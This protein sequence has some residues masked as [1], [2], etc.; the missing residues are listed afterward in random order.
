MKQVIEVKNITLKPGEGMDTLLVKLRKE[1]IHTDP[2]H[3]RIVKKS[4][5]ARDKRDLHY[6]CT[7]RIEGSLSKRHS[8]KC[9]MVEEMHYLP[10][11]PGT[12]ILTRR[13]VIVGAGPAGLF[14]GLLLAEAGYRPLILERGASL[15]ERRNTVSGFWRGERLDPESNVSFGE[16][17]AG[18]FSDGKLNTGVKDPFGR[19]GFVL[20]TFVDCGADP[21][22]RYWYKPHIGSDVLPTVVKNLRNRIISAGGEVRFHQKLTDL[23]TEGGILTGVVTEEDGVTRVIPT[24]ILILAIGHSARDTITMLDRRLPLEAKAFAVG[25]RIEHPQELIQLSQYGTADRTDLPVADYKL[26][27]QSSSGRGVYSFCMCPG[28]QVVN[29]SSEPGMVAV[30][31][32]SLSARD[33]RNANSAMIVSVKPEDYQCFSKFSGSSALS[34]IAFQRELERLAYREGDGAIPVQR[35]EDFFQNRNTTCYGDVIPDTC[36]AH[37]FANLRHVLPDMLAAPLIESFSNSARRLKGFDLPDAMLSGVETRTSSPVRIPRDERYES[38]IRG[39]F[40]CGEGAGYAGGITS[41]AM[42]GMRVAEEIIRR[43][44]NR[45]GYSEN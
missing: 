40:P 36:G 22:I 5:D 44:D 3:V 6:L 21:E 26:T 42:D 20:D 4:L 45:S 38:C 18:T 28:G 13:P 29:A 1:G 12:G 2:D 25:L 35:L 14:A 32:M 43:Y 8:A 34:G 39:L 30:N 7:L 37:V 19:I 16:G 31:G 23:R 33:G 27:Y 9:S 17:G 10:P 11:S 24:D 41:A 15:E